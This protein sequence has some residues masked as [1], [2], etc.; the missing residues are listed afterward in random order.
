MRIWIASYLAAFVDVFVLVNV[1]VVGAC[2][3]DHKPP[4]RPLLVPQTAAWAG[5]ADGG[6]WVDCWRASDVERQK[7]GQTHQEPPDRS[8]FEDRFDCRIFDERGAI[9]R[10]ARFRLLDVTAGKVLTAASDPHRVLQFSGWDGCQLH[11]VPARVL[12]DE[13]ALQCTPEGCVTRCP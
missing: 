8:L 2:T 5:G 9:Q 11:A 3:P 10:N 1:I 13:K 7:D 4:P 6:A 12:V